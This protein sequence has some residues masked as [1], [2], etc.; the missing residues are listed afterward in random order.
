MMVK[1]WFFLMIGYIVA[2]CEGSMLSKY[3]E[4]KNDVRSIINLLENDIT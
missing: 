1:L 4:Y 3:R 2:I